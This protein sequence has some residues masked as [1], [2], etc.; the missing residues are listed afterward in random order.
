MLTSLAFKLQIQD[1][2]LLWGKHSL[3]TYRQKQQHSVCSAGYL[4]IAVGPNFRG[5]G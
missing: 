1:L 3:I 4:C 2:H 5:V